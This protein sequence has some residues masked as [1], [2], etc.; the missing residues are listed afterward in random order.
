MVANRWLRFLDKDNVPVPIM[1]GE[2]AVAG[3]LAPGLKL[4]G[5]GGYGM[6]GTRRLSL[7]IAFFPRA[8]S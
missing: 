8:G 1:R 4:I 5:T 2:F 6:P 7:S 3:I